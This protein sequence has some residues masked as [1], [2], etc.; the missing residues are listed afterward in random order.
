MGY[1]L[2]LS[3]DADKADFYSLRRPILEALY[4]DG[5]YGAWA[6]IWGCPPRHRRARRPRPSPAP[7][8]CPRRKR[9]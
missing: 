5:A 8:A 4:A 7:A 1:D 3:E 2:F 6:G 9:S